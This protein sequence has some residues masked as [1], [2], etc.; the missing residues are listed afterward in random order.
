MSFRIWKKGEGTATPAGPAGSR[1]AAGASPGAAVLA[2]DLVDSTPRRIVTMAVLAAATML[3][4]AVV[5]RNHPGVLGSSSASALWIVGVG[6]AVGASLVMAWIAG[7]S[8]LPTD[9]LLDAAL[10]YEV[11]M[12]LFL[13]LD[14]YSVPLQRGRRCPRGWSGVAVW[15]LAYPLI[16]PATRGKMILATIA[17]AAMDPLGL[18]LQVAAGMPGAAAARPRG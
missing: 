13:S 9:R 1:G 7:R 11:A 18:G 16:V 12:A 10:V 8:M 6:G 5:D 4:F 2:P 14:F 3:V 15:M 17:T